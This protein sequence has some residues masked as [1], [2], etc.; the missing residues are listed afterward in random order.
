MA[1]RLGFSW[2]KLLFS[3]YQDFETVS[4]TEHPNQKL[5]RNK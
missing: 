4:A 5:S 2:S 1:I 3:V